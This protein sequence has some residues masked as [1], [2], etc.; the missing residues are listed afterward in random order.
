MATHKKHTEQS[1]AAKRVAGIEFSVG[2]NYRRQFIGAQSKIRSKK[3]KDKQTNL[4]VYWNVCPRCAVNDAKGIVAETVTHVKSSGDSI[5]L[6]RR[7]ACCSCPFNEVFVFDAGDVHFS[8]LYTRNSVCICLLSP[9]SHGCCLA[10]KLLM[11]GIG[12]LS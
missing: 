2:H 12:H 3:T 8:R 9:F 10:R 7:S 11:H 1:G 5:L 6:I 4:C